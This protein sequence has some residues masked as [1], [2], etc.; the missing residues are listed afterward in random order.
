MQR[1][2]TG[3][4]ATERRDAT[5]VPSCAGD[6]RPG[7]RYSGCDGVYTGP[8]P[9]AHAPADGRCVFPDTRAELETKTVD[10]EAVGAGRGREG[11]GVAFINVK[12]GCC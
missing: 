11:V 9:L 8:G 1:R 10:R 6:D 7:L 2:W 12:L 5:V 4:V 3:A